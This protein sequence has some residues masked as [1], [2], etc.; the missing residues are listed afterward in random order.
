M[1]EAERDEAQ[2]QI[3][4]LQGA[5][6]TNDATKDTIPRPRKLKTLSI[7]ELRGMFGLAG[8]EHDDKWNHYRV[9][10]SPQQLSCS[11]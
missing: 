8:P 11:P 7:A 9:R 10:D 4:N 3:A 5:G 6:A 2:H 1:A